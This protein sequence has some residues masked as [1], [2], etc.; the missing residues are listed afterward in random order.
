[1]IE[2]INLLIDAYFNCLFEARLKQESQAKS[3]QSEKQAP[4]K[5]EK[6]VNNN[7]D[8]DPPF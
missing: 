5:Q 1:M 7:V 3:A 8:E 6:S 4:P 2:N